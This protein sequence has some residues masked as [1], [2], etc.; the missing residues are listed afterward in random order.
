[1]TEDFESDLVALDLDLEPPPDPIAELVASCIDYVRNAVG[2]ELDL[3]PDTLPILDHYLEG[4][5]DA[6]AERPELL[7]LLSRSAGAY[8]GEVIRRTFAAFWMLPSDDVYGWRLGL[9]RVYLAMNPIGAVYEALTA[10][11]EHD[12]PSSELSLLR[13]E[14]ESVEAR[15]ATLPDVSEEDYFRLSTRFEVIRDRVRGTA[16]GDGARGRGSDGVRGRRLPGARGPSVATQGLAPASCVP[17][18]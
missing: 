2:V 8:F 16:R 18:I 14:Q 11:S 5:R 3:T 4:A 17:P 10:T 12:G 7:M 13:E 1:M 15:L 9:R 6:V